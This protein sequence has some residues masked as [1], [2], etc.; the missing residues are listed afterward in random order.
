MRQS[1]VH[2]ASLLVRIAVRSTVSKRQK[3]KHE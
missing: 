3:A 1:V 2:L